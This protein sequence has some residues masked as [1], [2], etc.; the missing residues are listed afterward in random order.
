MVFV[1]TKYGKSQ[2]KKSLSFSIF[3]RGKTCSNQKSFQ[4]KDICNCI[5]CCRVM[6]RGKLFMR[7]WHVYRQNKETVLVCVSP[8]AT[9]AM[10]VMIWLSSIQKGEQT[11]TP[12]VLLWVCV[13][14]F[15]FIISFLMY[16]YF[17]HL[18]IV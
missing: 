16:S 5:F 8:A 17:W 1:S 11:E 2:I 18:K 3:N 4:L 9:T 6:W 13:L 15:F 14:L 7:V 12:S 10:K